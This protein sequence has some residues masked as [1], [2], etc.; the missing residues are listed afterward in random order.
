MRK[1][2]TGLA[3]IVLAT[4]AAAQP[5]GMGP[6]MMGG[7]YRMGPGMMGGY[8]MGP[9]MM[10]E[11]GGM[12]PGMMGWGPGWGSAGL[13]GLDLSKEQRDKIADIQGEVR[14]KQWDL[15]RAM[16][17]QGWHMADAWHD[18]NFDE[19]A[20]RKAFDAMTAL[21]KSMFDLSVDAWK[22]IDAVLTP[23]QR[24]QLKRGR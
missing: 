16:H 9:G 23:A 20:A 13:G 5:Y 17:E 18:G 22:R 1:A 8:G 2:L 6:G 14:R 19:P 4:A 15:M 12:G 11:G 21:R 10:G 24:E 7:G 3:G